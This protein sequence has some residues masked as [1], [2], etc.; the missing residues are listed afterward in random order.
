MA[1]QVSFG[2]LRTEQLPNGLPTVRVHDV[3]QEFFL[4]F[5]TPGG[6]RL[7]L[8]FH[9]QGQ[10]PASVAGTLDPRAPPAVPACRPSAGRDTFDGGSFP[11]AEAGA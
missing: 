7:E 2:D 10:A 9:R 8:G 3:S 11:V 5:A 4:E 1:A 6:D